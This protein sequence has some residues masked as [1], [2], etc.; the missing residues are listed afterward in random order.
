M[1]AITSLV[2]LLGL[3]TAALSADITGYIAPSCTGDVSFKFTSPPSGACCDFKFEVDSI[4]WTLPRRSNGFA[5]AIPQCARAT[6][7]GPEFT[8]T[9]G[10]KE[11]KR[12]CVN[13]S[14]PGVVDVRV[15][16]AKWVAE[17]KG[18]GGVEPRGEKECLNPNE[19]AYEHEGV[20]YSKAIPDGKY[21]A[22]H[23]WVQAGDYEKLA[24]LEDAE[25]AEE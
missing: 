24:E 13:Y 21:D 6:R 12:R 17:G 10:H 16:S 7:L 5:Y 25:D 14:S 20:E 2:S 1:V 22:V 9:A 11:I 18:K 8:V 19:V 23:A 4:R 3:A 15:R